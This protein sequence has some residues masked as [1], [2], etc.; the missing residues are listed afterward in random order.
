M[1]QKAQSLS[2]Y[3][4]INCVESDAEE[5]EGSVL[6]PANESRGSSLGPYSF[7]VLQ[8]P[9]ALNHA[10]TTSQVEQYTENQASETYY[11][12]KLVLRVEP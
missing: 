2:P 8:M 5:I 4:S 6:A 9:L 3:P 7:H 11:F 12:C 10:I 1:S